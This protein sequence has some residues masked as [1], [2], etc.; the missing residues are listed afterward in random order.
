MNPKLKKT[1]EELSK[2][3]S[4]IGKVFLETIRQTERIKGSKL[5]NIDP[6]YQIY[7]SLQYTNLNFYFKGTVKENWKGVQVKTWTLQEL[8]ATYMSSTWC[9]CLE[10]FNLF[11]NFKVSTLDIEIKCLRLM[12]YLHKSSNLWSYNENKSIWS[13]TALLNSIFRSAARTPGANREPRYKLR[14]NSPAWASPS[15]DT[16]HARYTCNTS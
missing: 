16:M 6:R 7:F 8:M 1:E 11:L 13:I 12:Q 4:G 15:R 3:S 10:K 5:L 14:Y 9:S 2:I